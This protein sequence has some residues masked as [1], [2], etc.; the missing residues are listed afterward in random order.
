MG[1]LAG[2]EREMCDV[3]VSG[4]DAFGLRGLA[5]SVYRAERVVAGYKA[6]IAAAAAVLEASGSGPAV[7]ETLGAGCAVSAR[8]AKQMAEQAAVTAKFAQVD[9]VARSGAAHPE[10]VAALCSAVKGLSSAERAALVRHDAALARSARVDRPD[11]FVALLRDKVNDIRAN[12]SGDGLSLIERQRAASGLSIRPRPDGMHGIHGELDAE[13]GAVLDDVVEQTARGLAGADQVTANHRAAALFA[14][15]T[16]SNN[17]D[18]GPAPKMAIGFI[19]DHRTATHGPH[20]GTVAETW[21]GHPVDPADIARLACDADHYTVFIDDHGRPVEVAVTA[22]SATRAQRLALRVLYPTCPIDGT[23]PF[24]DCHIH[25]LVAW[26]DHGPTSITNLAPVSHDWHHKIHHLGWQ[27]TM[28]ADRTL[29]LTRPDGTHD[30]TIAPPTPITR[31]G[32]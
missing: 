21:H 32:P 17:G 7:Q 1:V 8:A 27:L 6:R 16:R 3:D 12:A 20:R 29:T 4:L 2:L 18:D 22:R 15:V 30:R 28:S 9:E 13:R 14:L 5:R 10:N 24:A 11:M 19:V 23:T 31:H 26:D 25:H